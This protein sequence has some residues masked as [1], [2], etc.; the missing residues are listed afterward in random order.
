MQPTRTDHGEGEYGKEN[1][2]VEELDKLDAVLANYIIEIEETGKKFASLEES[3]GEFRFR[4][5]P[6]VVI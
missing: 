5:I 6:Q 1:R 2:V 3:V 4:Q